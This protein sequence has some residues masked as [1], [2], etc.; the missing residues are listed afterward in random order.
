M[1]IL[2]VAFALATA[3]DGA[4][5]GS[6]QILAHI[7]RE[8]V[9]AGHESLVVAAEDSRVSGKLFG[10]ATRPAEVTHD[11]YFFRYNEHARAIRK[12]LS[13]GPVDLVHMHGVDFHEFLPIIDAPL[14]A[15]LHLPTEWYPSW[16]FQAR[17]PHFYLN[18][19]SESQRRTA[20]QSSLIMQTIANGIEIPDL[21]PSHMTS[22]SGA[23]MLGRICPEKG[24]HLGIAAARAAGMPVTIA[25]Q[26]FGYPEHLRYFEEQIKPSLNDTAVFLGPVGSTVKMQLLRS[27]KCVLVPSLAPETSSLVSMEALACGTPV[28]AFGAGALPEIVEHGRTGFIVDSANEMAETMKLVDEISPHECRMAAAARFSADRMVSEYICLYEELMAH[29]RDNV[30]TM[31][32]A[33]AQPSYRRAA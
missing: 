19:V 14:L 7:D 12:A 1:R 18:C 32:G 16:V 8:L 15:T 33:L 21:V 22:R 10:T 25:G 3:G 9:A 31:K 4:A 6:E 28:I 11:Y 27:A 24:V 23:V 30:L 2:T 13:S 26:V 5:G 20:P 29:R 17:R